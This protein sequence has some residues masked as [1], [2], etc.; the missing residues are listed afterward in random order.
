MTDLRRISSYVLWALAIVSGLAVTAL[1]L[2]YVQFESERQAG[3]RMRDLYSPLV[4][5]ADRIEVQATELALAFSD[6]LAAAELSVDPVRI[7]SATQRFVDRSVVDFAALDQNFSRVARLLRKLP[8]SRLI[9]VLNRSRT[10]YANLVEWRDRIDQGTW[11]PAQAARLRLGVSVFVDRIHQMRKLFVV[12]HQNQMARESDLRQKNRRN[13]QLLL[14]IV[15]AL[16][17][18]SIFYFTRHINRL[19]AAHENLRSSLKSSE[20]KLRRAQRLAK[21]GQWELDLTTDKLEWSDETFEIFG[22]NRAN[23]TGNQ[24]NFLAILHDDD[25]KVVRE[26]LASIAEF[27]GAFSSEYRIF[28]ANDGALR[29]IRGW[30]EVEYDEAGRPRR[31]IGTLQDVTDSERAKVELQEREAR[32]RTAE[33]VARIG[34]WEWDAKKDRIIWSDQMYEIFGLDRDQFIG[35]RESGRNRVHPNDRAHVRGRIDAV[36]STGEPA[37]YDYRIVRGDGEIRHVQAFTEVVERRRSGAPLR[38]T[39][40]VQDITESQ[41]AKLA[42]E[43]SEASLRNAQRI[44]R[45]GNWDWDI[46]NNAFRWSEQVYSIFGVPKGDFGETFEAV[47]DAVYPDDRE[48]VKQAVEKSLGDGQP[49]SLEHRISWP[50]GTLRVVQAQAEVSRDSDGNALRM[51]GTV[52]DITEGYEI[53]KA[54]EAREAELRLIT[55]HLPVLIAYVDK[56]GY[57]QFAN[58]VCCQWYGRPREEIVG[59]HVSE[60]LDSERVSLLHKVLTGERVTIERRFPYGD[61]EDRDV[62]ADIIPHVTENGQIAGAFILTTDIS[63]YKRAAKLTERFG[64]IIESSTNEVYIFEAETFKFIHTNR[65]AQQNLGYTMEELRGLTP[66]DLGVAYTQDMF[67]D[68][69]G[70]LVAGAGDEV[71]IETVHRRKDGSLYDVEIRLRLS[72]EETPP[73]YVAIVQDITERHKAEEALRRSAQNFRDLVDRASQGILI[74]RRGCVIYTNQVAAEI[75]GYDLPD[76]I[77][78]P[79]TAFVPE[80]QRVDLK[81]TLEKGHFGPF[82]SKALR[83][84]GTLVPVDVGL[85]KIVWDGI[86]A[87]QIILTDISARKEAEEKLRHAQRMDAV[88][89]LT[90]GLAHDFNNLLAIVIGNLDILL[91]KIV[92]QP[93]LLDLG[94]TARHAAARGADLTRRLL[95]FARQQP[96]NPVTVDL[97]QRVREIM[98]LFEHSL[99]QSVRVEADLSPDLWPTTVDIGEFETTLLN[100]AINA[101]QAMPEGGKIVLRTANVEIDEEFSVRDRIIS[102]GHYVMVTVSDSGMG[103]TPEVLDQALEPFFTTKGI[104]E[105][106]GLGLSTVYGFVTQS[107]G[108]MDIKSTPGAGTTVELCFPKAT[109]TRS[110]A[111]TAPQEETAENPRGHRVLVVEDDAAVRQLAMLMTRELGYAVL[112]AADADEALDILKT[113]E[114]IDVLYTDIMLG[115]DLNGCELALGATKLRPGLKVLFTTGYAEKAISLKARLAEGQ[116]IVPKPCSKTELA[117]RLSRLLTP[118]AKAGAKRGPGNKGGKRSAKRAARNMR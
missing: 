94:T 76:L 39:G 78:I 30:A 88:G 19:V 48:I 80:N 61:S 54:L 65:A 21:L 15:L 17:A 2:M 14:A 41:A 96:L 29:Y 86:P 45:L 103:M 87:G 100:L 5:S 107:G 63:E 58:R 102:V 20:A 108:F 90:G 98:D 77:G 51:S 68:L 81:K 117:R 18:A 82:E 111:S 118:E 64:K 32:L 93:A 105:G 28:R 115:G 79:L 72:R 73:V 10:T 49:F 83:K 24:D 52:Q 110:R 3:S 33:R 59:T 47:L 89:Q 101:Q 36:L 57:Y 66:V 25:R 70:P 11:T 84:N 112:A 16:G 1:A 55:D 12:E 95:A 114:G 9:P 53:K 106:T 6:L 60:L 34:H 23:F 22:V 37:T 31:V 71:H 13:Q 104:G 26:R 4:V 74:Y 50:D 27:K 35:T 92:D 97:N 99:G 43:A 42:L 109:R 62:I 46:A 69:I 75:L 40:T 91:E 8:D 56:D 44:A 113:T 7:R 85:S 67:G 116:D 38:I